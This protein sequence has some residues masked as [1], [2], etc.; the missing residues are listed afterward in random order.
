MTVGAWLYVLALSQWVASAGEVRTLCEYIPRQRLKPSCSLLFYTN[1]LIHIVMLI[2]ALST[3]AT[4]SHS[5]RH[6]GSLIAS[7]NP[8]RY[9]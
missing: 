6:L 4:P 2:Q 8:W 9:P 3:R 1:S 5:K 7:V